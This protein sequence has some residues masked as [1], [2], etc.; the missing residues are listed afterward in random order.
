MKVGEIIDLLEKRA[1]KKDAYEWD[2]VGLLVGSK[3]WDV[4][5]VYIALDAT[6]EVIDR[7]VEQGANMLITHHPMIFSSMTQVVDSDYVGHRVMKLVE[8]HVAYYAMHTN[9]D[10][11]GMAEVCAKALKLG[12]AIPLEPLEAGTGGVYGPMIS[13]QGLTEH[14]G[15]GA[16]QGDTSEMGEIPLNIH[17]GLISE[18]SRSRELLTDLNPYAKKE[19][20][21]EPGLGCLGSL[22]EPVSLQEYAVYVK[23]A[24]GLSSV[25]VFGDLDQMLHIVALLPGSGK[26]EIDLAVQKGADVLVTGD[27]DHH[28]GLDAV[29]KGIAII[30]AGHYGMEHLFMEDISFYLKGLTGTLEVETDPKKE[31]FTVI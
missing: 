26:S 16:L 8:N 11:H 9:Y 27:I 4:N 2:N 31:P 5:K 3:D 20:H 18:F 15:E 29:E 30:D 7:A 13:L 24:L 25:R 19:Q 10:V 14:N 22:D 1:P 17:E 23:Q 28:S 21:L 12:H 6:G